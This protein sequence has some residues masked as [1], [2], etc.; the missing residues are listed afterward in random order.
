M[1][2]VKSVEDFE[3]L[4]N[5]LL[6]H[7]NVD[8]KKYEPDFISDKKWAYAM[9]ATDSKSSAQ[10]NVLGCSI[11]HL[12]YSTWKG[13]NL[14]IDAI[15][16]VQEDSEILG[17]EIYRSTKNFAQKSHLTQMR[18]LLD[19]PISHNFTSY[20]SDD[21]SKSEVWDIL[22]LPKS[23]ID[24]ITSKFNSGLLKKGWKNNDISIIEASQGHMKSLVKM[25]QDLAIYEELLEDCW[26]N[27]FVL[28]EHYC[29]DGNVVLKSLD[30][31]E[32]VVK[33]WVVMDNTNG[34]NKMIGY[35]C[36]IP[37]FSISKN[38]IENEGIHEEILGRYLYL[39]DLY[40][41]PEYR[42]QGIGINLIH[43]ICEYSKIRECSAIRWACLNWNQ[44][45]LDFY[46]QLGAENIVR[47]EKLRMYRE[48]FENIKNDD[49]EGWL[50]EVA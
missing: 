45:S 37:S 20:G 25:I 44:S 30:S 26:M 21:V 38:F 35:C 41:S 36:V 49:K 34:E 17:Q 12:A 1:S 11:S 22:H 40:V 7:Q 31:T 28:N 4:S 3:K 9:I 24:K 15:I 13:V 33:I 23:S 50:R 47:N 5:F 8:L 48:D 27:E 42:G 2:L 39:E 18:G 19:M 10:S 29:N 6:Q 46:E 43:K 32:P 14:V 16:T